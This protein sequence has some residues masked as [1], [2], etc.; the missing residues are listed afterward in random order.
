MI[1]HSLL[2]TLIIGHQVG[3]N[4]QPT[5]MVMFENCVIPEGNLLGNE[6]QVSSFYILF[7]ADSLICHRVFK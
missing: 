2:L 6:G 4:S 7:F 1:E 3:W 5:R